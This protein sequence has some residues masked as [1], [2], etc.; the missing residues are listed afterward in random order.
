MRHRRMIGAQMIILCLL[1]ASCGQGGQGGGSKAE[2]LALEIRT[3]YIGMTACTASMDVSKIMII[4]DV[5][6]RF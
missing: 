6:A 2:Q 5:R 3:E 1:L 4:Y